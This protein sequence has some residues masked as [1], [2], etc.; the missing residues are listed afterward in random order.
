MTTPTPW[1]PTPPQTLPEQE[2][3]AKPFVVQIV[4]SVIENPGRQDYLGQ[5]NLLNPYPD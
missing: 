3:G 2:A 1:I 4:N 5:Q